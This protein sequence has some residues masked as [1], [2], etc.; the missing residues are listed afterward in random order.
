MK[1]V[2]VRDF[3]SKSAKVWKQLAQEDGMVITSNGKP[4]ALLTSVS[5]EKL[6]STLKN[7][8]KAKAMTA[9]AS[10]QVKSMQ[11]G[12]GTMSL[13]EINNEIARARRD[14]NK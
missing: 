6:E 10:I 3:R 4:V 2:T 7:L 8:R 9:A 5:D 1:F 11:R 12:T 14:R 13:A